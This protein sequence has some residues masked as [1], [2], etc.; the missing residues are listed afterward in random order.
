MVHYLFLVSWMRHNSVDWYEIFRGLCIIRIVDHNELTCTQDTRESWCLLNSSQYCVS[1][2]YFSSNECN[3]LNYR[4]KI[5]CILASS[6]CY[7]APS[8]SSVNSVIY[9]WILIKLLQNLQGIKHDALEHCPCVVRVAFGTCLFILSSLLK[10]P[11]LSRYHLSVSTIL[12]YAIFC[13][14]AESASH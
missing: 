7:R 5:F 9:L 14:P 1:P 6:T 13:L 4:C 11:R 8:C 10:Y 3:T 2:R 12:L